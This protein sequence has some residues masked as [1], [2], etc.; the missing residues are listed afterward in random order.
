MA[1][2]RLWLR[3][4]K[5]GK[6]GFA[7]I[8]LIYQL[9]GQ[10]KYHNTQIKLRPSNWDAET[11]TAIYLNKKEAKE[12]LPTVDY[13]L[14]PSTKDIENTNADLTAIKKTFVD[15]ATDFE[16]GNVVY[17][18]EMVG[19][20][21]KELKKPE[22]KKD[23]KTSVVDF[24]EQYAKDAATTKRTGSL[25]VYNTNAGHLRDFETR[26]KFKVTFETI[27]ITT[28]KQFQKYLIDIKGM[29][30]TTVAKQLSTL[31]TL[32]NFARVEYKLKVNQDYRDFKISRKDA[33]HEVIVLTEDELQS[34]IDLDLSDNNRL[35]KV[36]DIFVFSCSTSLRFSDLEDLKREHIRGG[37]IKKTAVKTGQ[38]LDIPLTAVSDRIL[39]KYKDQHQPLPMIS[40]QKLND[41]LKEVGEMAG[42]D[43][44]IEKVREYGTKTKAE[45]F[46]KFELMSIHMGRRTFATL[47]L[48]RGMAPQDVMAI[49]AHSTYASFKRYINVNSDHKQAVMA[50]A[51]GAVPNKL[52]VAK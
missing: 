14:M 28:L 36:R 1:T 7:P 11:Q 52:K 49:T 6:D 23:I 3:T 44:L 33:N 21:V 29:N 20:T 41:Y 35:D 4:D 38:K 26:N 32:L 51:W 15:Q 31:K 13:D 43:T 45:T 47:S 30:N 17:S 40:S 5:I 8:H 19:S 12:L 22:T 27:D 37:S 10:R 2:I 42:I 25:S 9:H 48:Q 39:N 24:I 46:K 34:V 16:R 50:K 18:A